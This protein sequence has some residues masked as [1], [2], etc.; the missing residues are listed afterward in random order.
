[1]TREAHAVDSPLAHLCSC[2]WH[3]TVLFR[4]DARK[5]GGGRTPV[6]DW[7]ENVGPVLPSL[8]RERLPERA[9]THRK[10][11]VCLVDRCWHTAATTHSRQ[12]NHTTVSPLTIAQNLERCLLLTWAR[13][14][15]RGEGQWSAWPEGRWRPWPRAAPGGLASRT[16]APV[17]PPPAAC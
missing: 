9:H 2:M 1:M 3:I 6:A 12:N 8:R 11:R 7:H 16:R 13:S 4:S 10:Y 5:A 14:R 17:G 15:R